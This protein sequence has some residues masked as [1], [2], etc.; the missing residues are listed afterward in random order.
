MRNN[1]CNHTIAIGEKITYFISN[2]YKF[3]ENDKIEEVSLL[4]STNN[5][6]DPF[7]SYPKNVPKMFSK[8]QSVFKFIVVR[9]VLKEM[10]RMK[11]MIWL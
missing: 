11:M 3:I 5:S 6:L 10:K 7:D 9:L 8:R 4:N 2:H 1:M